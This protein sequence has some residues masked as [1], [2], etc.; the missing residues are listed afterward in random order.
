MGSAHNFSQIYANSLVDIGQP[1]ERLSPWLI[2]WATSP[3][4]AS[5]ACSPLCLRRGDLP[6]PRGENDPGTFVGQRTRR[7]ACTHECT[8]FS[9][10][11]AP[12]SHGQKIRYMIRALYGQF[13]FSPRSSARVSN[14][15]VSDIGN[16]FKINERNK[17][18]EL[19][20]KWNCVWSKMRKWFTD[21]Y[22]NTLN[23]SEG[24]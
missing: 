18:D 7:S 2:C 6:A 16:F 23:I 22:F 13:N 9:P 24:A 20:N 8:L 15:C 5:G 1:V 3:I 11:L 17:T 4:Y 19:I 21:M 12:V 14:G 10:R